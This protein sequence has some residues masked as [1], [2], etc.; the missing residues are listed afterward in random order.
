M[1]KYFYFIAFLYALFC[2][3]C[4]EQQP[5]SPSQTMGSSKNTTP[6]DTTAKVLDTIAAANPIPQP[7]TTAKAK[8]TPQKTIK[9]QSK[10]VA[11]TPKNKP[12]KKA[13][14]LPQKSI[15][16]KA[17]ENKPQK[18]IGNEYFEVVEGVY[19]NDDWSGNPY[20]V[21]CTNCRFCREIMVS[22][23]S[24]DTVYFKK[25]WAGGYVRNIT[26]QTGNGGKIGLGGC[27]GYGP[28]YTKSPPP[29]NL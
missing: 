11:A 8:T 4:A 14:E 2:L 18:V 17:K 29:H 6:L 5:A 20:Y 16:G 21:G 3:A 28:E 23:I 9:K 10:K 25:M 15:S 27:M 13:S 22:I 26:A 19:C 7:D 12:D 1:K 24:E